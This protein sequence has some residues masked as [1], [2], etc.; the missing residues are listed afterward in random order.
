[1]LISLVREYIKKATPVASSFLAGRGNF[2]L[3]S[4]TIR[5]EM[6]TLEE[7]GYITQPHTSAGRI[8]TELGYNFYLE[9]LEKDIE[10]SEKDNII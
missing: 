8:P 4:A 3:S 7:E 1:M 9:N 2:K 10:I 5:N 6:A